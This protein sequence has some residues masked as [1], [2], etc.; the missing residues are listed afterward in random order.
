MSNSAY[1]SALT[2]TCIIVVFLHYFGFRSKRKPIRICLGA[3]IS[4]QKSYELHA[5]CSNSDARKFIPGRFSKYG[6]EVFLVSPSYTKPGDYTFGVRG[7]SIEKL[8]D[9]LE[10]DSNFQVVKKES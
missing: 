10:Q 7:R 6:F 3:T 8:L 5:W 2:V 4:P 1:I 9:R